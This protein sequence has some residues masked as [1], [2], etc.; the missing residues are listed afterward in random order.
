MAN[1]S[2]RLVPKLARQQGKTSRAAPGPPRPA[3]PFKMELN[4]LPEQTSKHLNGWQKACLLFTLC[5]SASSAVVLPRARPRS[6]TARENSALAQPCSPVPVGRHDL[7]HVVRPSDP[8]SY[9]DRAGLT[10]TCDLWYGV[11]WTAWRRLRSR[12]PLA[13][14]LR[15]SFGYVVRVP[16]CRFGGVLIDPP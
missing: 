7:C 9:S 2:E 15:R 4:D 6:L 5:Y 16:A 12:R 14:P 1:V 8:W 13:S 11:S 3:S 10:L